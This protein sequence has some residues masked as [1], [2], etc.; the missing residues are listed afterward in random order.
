MN[1]CLTTQYWLWLERCK[2]HII[3]KIVRFQ[4][5]YKWGS[6]KLIL[7]QFGIIQHFFTLFFNWYRLLS[8][9]TLTETGVDMSQFKNV[10]THPVA[11]LIFR[12]KIFIPKCALDLLT[13]QVCT[14][15]LYR[16]VCLVAREHTLE[17][18]IFLWKIRAATGGVSSFLN[19]DMS[20]PVSVRVTKGIWVK[21]LYL[22][23]FLSA[24]SIWDKG[25]FYPNIQMKSNI[26]LDNFHIILII[27]SLKYIYI[28]NDIY[29][30]SV[31]INKI[32]FP[33]TKLWL[34]LRTFNILQ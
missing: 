20:A 34:N 11:D 25:E 18:I 13:P 14:D 26:Y 15:Q 17:R 12:K 4:I 23:T 24:M 31:W 33:L 5:N 2:D 16:E 30:F 8:L 19:R 9:V 1:W 7:N 29:V 6:I 21:K 22:L 28:I 32:S 27:L 10:L 3:V